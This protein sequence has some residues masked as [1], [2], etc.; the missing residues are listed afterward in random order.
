MA[1]TPEAAAQVASNLDTPVAL[2][3]QVLTGGRGLAGAIKFG[4]GSEEVREIAAQILRMKIGDERPKTILVEEK[5]ESLRELYVGVTWDYQ[6]KCP[7]VVGSSRGGVDIESVAKEY[8]KDVVRKEVDPLKGFSAYLGRELAAV[9]GL[10]GDQLVQ[11]ANLVSALWK[12]FEEH[13]AELVEINPVA[14]LE[15]GKLVALD[16]KLILDDKSIFRQS[17]LVNR[18]EKLPDDVSEGLTHRRNRARDRGIPTYI[19]MR[20]GNI[21]VVADGAGSGMLTLDLVSD[22]GGRTRVYCEMGGEATAQLIENA[23]LTTMEMTDVRVVLVN[24][25]GGLNRMDEMARGITS[26]FKTHP[27]EIPIV[28]RMSGTMQDEGRRILAE[29][30]IPFFDSLYEAVQKAVDISQGV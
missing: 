19:E 25:I 6:R 11:Y 29:S 7:V 5:L 16:A 12:I 17:S 26:C 2:K 14:V 1:T 22:F 30:G 18:I 20:Q 8:P 3:A 21:G 15:S 24:L 27:S 28:V 4:Q 13:D 10:T 9:I 23:L